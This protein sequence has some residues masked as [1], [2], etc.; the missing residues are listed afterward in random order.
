MF[1]L[2]SHSHFCITMFLNDN[3]GC[4][5]IRQIRPRGSKNMTL[6][7]RIFLLVYSNTNLSA[8]VFQLTSRTFQ[9]VSLILKESFTYNHFHNISR[10]FDVLPNFLF[11]ANETMASITYKHSI[12]DLPHELQNDLR[13]RI[14][15]N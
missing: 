1:S 9:Y 14:L 4:N 2:V 8:V 10:L 13:L 5:K 3:F 11:P 12:Y 15:G 6:N 7:L